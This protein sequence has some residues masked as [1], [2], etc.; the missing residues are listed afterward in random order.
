MEY[1]IK[2]M[3]LNIKLKCNYEMLKNRIQ[4]YLVN[5]S[6]VT[7]DFTI[8]YQD[9]FL[10]KEASKN[11][12]LRLE[13]VEYILT[14]YIFYRK[15]LNYNAMLIHSSSV[16]VEGKAYCF[17]ADSGV[18][19]STHT[20]LYLRYLPNSYII[21]DDKPAYRLI[22]KKIYVY[23]TPWSGKNDISEN[24]KVPLQGL[25]FIARSKNNKI[26]KLSHK[27]AIEKI[28]KQ[29]LVIHDSSFLNKLLDLLN[30]ILLTYN[31][32][33]LECDISKEAFEMSYNTLKEDNYE[34]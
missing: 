9:D 12:H 17:S 27:E 3:D 25:C 4:K 22:D 14:S 8:D 26:K 28:M 6:N 32:Y 2:V 10:F 21:N 16:V 29:T 34:N 33:E 7:I 11:P 24:T 30:E 18:G 15:I 19:K 20:S 31:V 1:I 23:G 13:E 5:D